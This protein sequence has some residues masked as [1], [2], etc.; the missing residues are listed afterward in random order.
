MSTQLRISATRSEPASATVWIGTLLPRIPVFHSLVVSTG[1]TAC[2]LL[3][4]HDNHTRPGTLIPL[5]HALRFAR[6]C[7]KCWT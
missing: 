5:R 6:P 3:L 7:G 4:W 2:G 1:H